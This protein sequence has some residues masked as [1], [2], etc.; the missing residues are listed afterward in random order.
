MPRGHACS[1]GRQCGRHGLLGQ[2][3][4]SNEQARRGGQDATGNPFGRDWTRLT[5]SLTAELSFAKRLVM[6]GAVQKTMDA[7][8]AATERL[9]LVLEAP[10][11][12]GTAGTTR[13]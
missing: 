10:E 7:E 3:G 9:K 6:S 2:S 12:N 11:P 4:R 13:G 8:V 5:S 1:S